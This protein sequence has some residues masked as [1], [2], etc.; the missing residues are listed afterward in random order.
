VHYDGI[1][2]VIATVKGDR[3]STSMRLYAL[4]CTSSDIKGESEGEKKEKR[5]GGS[6]SCP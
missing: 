5:K 1:A 3:S 2:M 4:I 6:R